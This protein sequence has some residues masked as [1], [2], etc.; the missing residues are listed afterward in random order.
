MPWESHSQVPGAEAERVPRGDSGSRTPFGPDLRRNPTNA[1]VPLPGTSQTLS[2]FLMGRTR[3]RSPD[4]EGIQESVGP[5]CHL[6]EL[7]G[8][9]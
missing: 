2:A 4:N 8:L 9:S 1:K 5:D 7:S 6:E 3:V